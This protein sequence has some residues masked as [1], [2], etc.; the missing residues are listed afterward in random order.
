MAPLIVSSAYWTDAPWLGLLDMRRHRAPP[1]P[2]SAL[3]SVRLTLREGGSIHG[4]AL[5]LREVWH[6]GDDDPVS[7]QRLAR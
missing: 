5:Y 1:S 3:A 4:R 7:P 6:C 2:A